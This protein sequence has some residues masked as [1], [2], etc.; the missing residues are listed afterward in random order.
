MQSGN[1]PE[2]IAVQPSPSSSETRVMI[3]GANGFVGRHLIAYLLGEAE[4]AS[5]PTPASEQGS[6]IIPSNP[7]VPPVS[8]TAQVIRIFAG[9]HPNDVSTMLQEPTTS[10]NIFNRAGWTSGTANGRIEIVGLELG[11]ANG[12]AQLV[13]QI[14]P[15]YICHLA[16]K[17]SGAASDRDNVF[18]VNVMG[19]RHLLEAAAQV[20]P[21]PHVLLASTG[22]VYGDTDP[23]RPAREEDPIGPLWRYGVYTDSK[24]EMETVARAYRGFVLVTRAFAHTGPGQLPTFAVPAFATQIVRMERGLEPPQLRVGNLDAWRDLMDVRDV[25]RAYASLMN[26]EPAEA[27]G[28]KVSN[29]YNALI[30]SDASNIFNV[31]NV[32][33]GK[34]IQMR[35]IVERLC[36]LSTAKPEIVIDP[37]RL[38]PLDIACSTGDPSRLQAASNWRPTYTLDQTLHDMLDHLRRNI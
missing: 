26:R 11:N 37:A 29:D 15:Q 24:I 25:V 30:D 14:Q 21:F 33:T 22:Y 38:R 36:A 35:A 12:L 28:G 16:A 3:T 32:A 4:A 19:T 1:M 20:Q 9:V 10:A 31:F 17:S 34:P 2:P 8:R 5:S 23:R 18:A 6:S 7:S 13:R 27:V